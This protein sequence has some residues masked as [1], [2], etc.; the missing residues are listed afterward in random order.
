MKCDLSGIFI[1][2]NLM[3]RNLTSISDLTSTLLK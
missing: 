3:T 1:G 2:H